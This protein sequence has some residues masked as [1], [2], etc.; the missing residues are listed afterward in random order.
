MD[1]I[2]EGTGTVRPG[3]QGI[4]G[5]IKSSIL[6]TIFEKGRGYQCAGAKAAD[7][8]DITIKQKGMA[9][10]C[11]CATTG[12]PF[13]GKTDRYDLFGKLFFGISTKDLLFEKQRIYPGLHG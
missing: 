6:V 1:V 7:R 2:Q 5:G 12:T 11:F 4:S 10:E 8:G 3:S 13:T 9:L